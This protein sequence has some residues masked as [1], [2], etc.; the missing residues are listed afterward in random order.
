MSFWRFY[1]ERTEKVLFKRIIAIT[2]ALLMTT[3]SFGGY[4]PA[5][6]SAAVW[7]DPAEAEAETAP[8]EIAEE[9]LSEIPEVEAEAFPVEEEAQSLDI[10][11][12]KAGDEI[13]LTVSAKTG[14]AC[15]TVEISY[16]NYH[17]P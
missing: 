15:N 8:V 16:V 2:L 17:R 6:F 3:D 12:A 14:Y 13:A 5:G 9:S 7:A 4:I 11:E 1:R 10:S